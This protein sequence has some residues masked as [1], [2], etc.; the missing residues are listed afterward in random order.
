MLINI[1]IHIIWGKSLWISPET[2]D[3]SFFCFT[4]FAMI[5][6]YDTLEG[7]EKVYLLIQW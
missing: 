3:S 7:L 1:K 4:Y 5:K 2:L 6:N